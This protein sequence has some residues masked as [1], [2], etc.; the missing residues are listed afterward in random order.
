MF[1]FV[2]V[3]MASLSV[4]WRV[5]QTGLTKRHSKRAMPPYGKRQ[6]MYIARV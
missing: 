3:V 2:R 6:R 1:E 4:C 5:T